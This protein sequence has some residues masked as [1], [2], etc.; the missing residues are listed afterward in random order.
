MFT[1]LNAHTKQ[2]DVALAR[3]H[4]MPDPGCKRQVCEPEKSELKQ[5][6][7]KT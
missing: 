6:K 3:M 2:F 5:G 7:I 4:K 1:D